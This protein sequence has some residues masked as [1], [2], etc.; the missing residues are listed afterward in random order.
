MSSLTIL[1]AVEFAEK[2]H[3][4]QTRKNSEKTPYI[5]HP[6]SVA[7]T[8]AEIGGVT[9]TDIIV[10][11]LLH[12]TVEDTDTE[13]EDLIELFGST[14]ANLVKEVTDDKSLPKQERK[15][16]QV[17]HATHISSGA[18]CIKLGDKICNCGD[19]INDPP[20]DWDKTRRR[21]YLDW[22]KR[23]IDNCGKA[24]D[25]LHDHFQALLEKG[26]KKIDSM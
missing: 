26:Y 11:A 23:V 3:R 13:L 2:K 7:K 15:E 4:G 20:S 8:I 10:A 19:V 17:E 5:S 22:A 14:V 6:L 9:D 25:S 12:D 1:Q 24:N 21:E 18:A 16:R